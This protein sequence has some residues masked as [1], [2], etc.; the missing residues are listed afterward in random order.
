VF[1]GHE[2]ENVRKHTKCIFN[3]NWLTA[4]CSSAF[5]DCTHSY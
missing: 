1:F 4:E 3:C 2:T 5:M